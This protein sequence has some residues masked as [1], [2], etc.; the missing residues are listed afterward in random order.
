M[1]KYQNLSLL[2]LTETPDIIIWP[3]YA[4]PFDIITQNKSLRE[5][6][7]E[8]IRKTNTP[9]IIGSMIF[10]P[11]TDYHEN[12][13]LFFDK[14]GQ[15][16]EYYSSILPLVFNRYAK[17]G[18]KGVT[19][20]ENAG[21]ALCW[22]EIDPS[23][24]RTMTSKGAKYLIILSNEQDLSRSWLLKFTS[25]FSKTRAS[26]NKRFVARATNTG[27]SQIIDPYGRILKQSP[28][29]EAN[30]LVKSISLIT[31][32]TFYTL[33]GEIIIKIILFILCLLLLCRILKN[34][35]YT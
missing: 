5:T 3:E 24:L 18:T 13:A 26:E 12:T 6:I 21:V 20:L 2:A 28:I 29:C 17:N 16:K 15:L 34:K 31:E 14:H 19:L 8:N 11:T 32:K 9:Y 4:L 25:N 7:S 23:I 22:E 27:I 30:Y 10:D 35:I 1:Q 33:H